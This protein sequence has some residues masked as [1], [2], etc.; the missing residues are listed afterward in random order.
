VT[1]LVLFLI[2]FV[3]C[4]T[5][6]FYCLILLTSIA[7]ICFVGDRLPRRTVVLVCACCLYLFI[8]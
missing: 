8:D 1:C 4:L 6:M 7:C 5:V 2:Y 3:I